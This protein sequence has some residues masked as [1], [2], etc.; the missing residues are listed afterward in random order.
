MARAADWD[1]ACCRKCVTISAMTGAGRLIG[2]SEE[3][4]ELSAGIDAVAAGGGA[5][6]L[7]SGEPG[8]GKTRLV[9]DLVE[10]ARAEG[11]D[12]VRGRAVPDEGAP[13]LW[14]WQQALR[15]RPER[16]ILTTALPAGDA[17]LPAAAA[18]GAQWQAFEGVLSG[19]STAA[20]DRG[21]AVVLED[22]HWADESTAERMGRLP[23]AAREAVAACAVLGAECLDHEVAVLCEQAPDQAVAALERAVGVGLLVAVEPAPLRVAFTHELTR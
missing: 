14:A 11:L 4:A 6:L 19:L 21:L 7:I 20:A 23:A 5:T 13:P 16:P 10:R 17:D 22:V 15:C 2:R 8:I 9:A 1:L 12:V 3:L 18:R